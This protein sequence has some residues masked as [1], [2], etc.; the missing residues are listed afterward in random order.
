M[1]LPAQR[2]SGNISRSIQVAIADDTI[3]VDGDTYNVYP[4][5]RWGDPDEA[6]SP[7]TDPERA[8]VTLTWL[9]EGAG[10]KDSSVLQVD[11]YSRIQAPTDA[12][13]DPFGLR[14]RAIADEIEY[15]FTG[16]NAEGALKACIRVLDYASDP[17]APAA[18]D[19]FVVCRSASGNLGEADERTAAGVEGEMWRITLTF[20]FYL[21]LD[22]AGRDAL[23]YTQ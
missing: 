14:A 10:R 19:G 7:G 22:L 4:D 9:R 2:Q 8:F 5:Y 13:G 17:V 3:T 6:G 1:P 23:Y 16:V 18:T 21:D 12:D 15:G 20:R 11:V